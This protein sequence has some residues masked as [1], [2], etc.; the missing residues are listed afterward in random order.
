MKII[1]GMV[2]TLMVLISGA[3]FFPDTAARAGDPD[4]LPVGEF[5]R[6]ELDTWIPK[7]FVNETFYSLALVDGKPSLK[8]VSRN[9]ASG[10]IKKIQVDIEKYPFLNWQWRIENRLEGTFDEK[11]KSGDDYA[12]RIYIVVSGGIAVWNT[13]ALNYVWAKTSPR[14]ETWPNAFAGKNAVM[15][16]LR[17]SDDPV[18]TWQSEKRN[19][20]EDFKTVFKE[21]IRF[22][23]A[24]VLMSDT[25]NTQ[26]DVTA[27]YGD[28][29]FSAH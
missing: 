18:G 11:Q 15:K 6:Q 1:A 20:R 29:Y 4:I 3:C 5:S 8:A 21:N 26:N 27:Y 28:I 7:K 16:A 24:V 2:T 13:R 10:L 9:S 23:D 19:V 12:A 25:D 22:I 14:E 17:S